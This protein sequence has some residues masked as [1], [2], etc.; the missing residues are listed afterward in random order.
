MILRSVMKHVRDQNWFAVFLDF[1]IVV[2]G[3]FIGIQVANWNEAQAERR[4]LN[5]QLSS[6]H[7][8][9]TENLNRFDR[10]GQRLQAKID[11]IQTL[12]S[13]IAGAPHE[14]Q[15]D[16]LDRM[17]MNVF[18]VAVF[19]ADRTT[20]DE[21]KDSGKFLQLRSIGIRQPLVEWE[22]AFAGLKRLEGDT[23]GFRNRE[24]APFAMDQLGFAA[25]GN[26]YAAAEKL[27][28]PSPFRNDLAM[29]EGNRKFDNI[30][31]LMLGSRAACLEFLEALRSQ[32]RA[33][34]E[35]LEEQGISS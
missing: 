18:S 2:V 9:F 27:V 17:L 16:A 22:E 32:T 24:F 8:E 14:G 25:M 33:V 11:D 15:D 29:L 7:A 19:T 20:L 31:T 23:I 35:R 21:L 5:D 13:L 34:L 3:V 6:L 4:I 10:Y 1:L 26:H 12:R 28:A 30:A